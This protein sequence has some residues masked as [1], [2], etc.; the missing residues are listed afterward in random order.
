MINYQNPEPDSSDEDNVD[1]MNNNMKFKLMGFGGGNMQGKQQ[2]KS[3]TAN[4]GQSDEF[5]MVEDEDDNIDLLSE[6]KKSKNHDEFYAAEELDNLKN[7]I[8]F[9]MPHM[10][11]GGPG[12]SQPQTNLNTEAGETESGEDQA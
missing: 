5:K 7:Q 8:K 2:Q 11:M 4:F 9:S 6:K 3:K 1:E 10:K 12:L